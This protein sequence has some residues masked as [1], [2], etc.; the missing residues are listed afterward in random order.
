VFNIGDPPGT[1]CTVSVVAVNEMQVIA[2][3]PLPG[4]PRWAVY[5]HATE[6]VYANMREPAQIVVLNAKELEIARAFN[7][8]MAGPHGLAIAGKRLFCAADGGALF[9]LDRDSGAVLSSV[10]LPGEPD[11]VMHDPALARLYVAIGSPG[12]VSVIDEQCLGTLETVPTESG[13]HT[14]G[15]NPDTRT[16]YAFL[17]VS[18]GAAVFTEQ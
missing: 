17:P 16:L 3:I 5:D 6:Q 14:I 2:T 18:G 1:N 8:P 7:V 13:A 11:V 9:A 4:R 15:W 10:A 12:V